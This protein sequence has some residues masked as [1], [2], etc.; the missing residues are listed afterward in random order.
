M[1]QSQVDD[2]W[3]NLIKA[4]QYMEFKAANKEDLAKVIALAEEM[5]SNLDKYLED[6]KAAF[7]S[8]L[9]EAKAVYENEIATQEEVN[10]AWQNLLNAIANM[11]LKPDKGLLEDLIAQAEGLNEADYE[12]QSFAAMR[13]AL[14]AAKEVLAD[15]N[16]TEEEISTSVAALEDALAKLTPVSTG[17]DQS[18]SGNGSQDQTGGTSD[19]DNTSSAGNTSSSKTSGTNAAKTGDTANALPI[20]AT[21]AAAALAAGAAV[22]LI[23]KKEDN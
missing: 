9:E 3:R 7:T 18:G 14:V 13:T 16:A 23:K 8:A 22:V 11:M 1:T 20:A 17:G 6:G 19:K 21:A 15:E 10:S 2:A 4:M 12:A 5:N